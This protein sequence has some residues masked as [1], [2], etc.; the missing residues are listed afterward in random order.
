MTFSTTRNRITHYSR[1]ATATMVCGLFATGAV[2]FSS[3]SASTSTLP[4]LPSHSL[5][6]A[7]KVDR[8]MVPV[9]KGKGNKVLHAFTARKTTVY[10][11]IA[12]SGSG[13]IKVPGMFTISSCK[14]KPSVF[15]YS[16]SVPKA[17]AYHPTVTTSSTT[18]W[19]IFITEGPK[20]P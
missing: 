4:P 19:E 2:E 9:T 3:A 15:G 5:A 11:Q 16:F 12:C 8:V 14:A 20:T 7:Q 17:W 6:G 18:K 10:V 13:S 1:I